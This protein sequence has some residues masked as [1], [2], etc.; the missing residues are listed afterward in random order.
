MI[1]LKRFFLTLFA[2]LFF[3]W[4]ISVKA[5]N[6]LTD[7]QVISSA[8]FS[9]TNAGKYYAFT[10]GEPVIQTLIG[11][12][13][14]RFTQ[15]FHQP[16]SLRLTATSII[17]DTNSHWE[18]K[19]FP[20]PARNELFLSIN[21]GYA[22]TEFTIQIFNLL[23]QPATPVEHFR[24]DRTVTINCSLL[25]EG[26]YSLRIKSKKEDHAVTLPFIKVE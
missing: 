5:Q 2:T 18:A 9:T 8:G 15:G 4:S 12:N 1:P 17:I 14:V 10:V 22:T 16:Y 20:N 21:A 3:G 23:G 13:S 11:Q 25:P 19:L 24:T 6:Y 7:M 26:Y